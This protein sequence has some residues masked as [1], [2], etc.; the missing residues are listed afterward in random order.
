MDTQG[1]IIS[2]LINEANKFAEQ[3][4][5]LGGG[6]N[7]AGM[8]APFRVKAG[9]RNMIWI[10]K[11]KKALPLC[12]GRK[13]KVL[14][15]YSVKI[16]TGGQDWKKGAPV[17]WFLPQRLF[18]TTPRKCEGLVVEGTIMSTANQ[19][20]AMS[21]I[22]LEITQSH[23]KRFWEC[24]AKKLV[25]WKYTN[26]RRVGFFVQKKA[27]NNDFIHVFIPRRPTR[28][29]ENFYLSVFI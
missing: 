19:N 14:W 28:N 21:A 26:T 17:W 29:R 10:W 1:A 18:R 27:K 16:G 25:R 12:F 5:S 13:V 8:I 11:Q 2:W 24:D 9:S 7:W 23:S 15:G 6:E 4:G 20:C 22:S 3:Q